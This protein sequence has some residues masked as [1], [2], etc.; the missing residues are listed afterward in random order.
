MTLF[1]T[2][3]FSNHTNNGEIETSKDRA[4]RVDDIESKALSHEEATV[5]AQNDILEQLLPTILE[6]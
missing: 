3:D 4:V 2:G 6:M 5:D 1:G